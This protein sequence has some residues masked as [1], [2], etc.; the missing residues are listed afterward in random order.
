M[1]L[2]IIG[3]VLLALTST[4]FGQQ[5]NAEQQEVWDM[6]ERCWAAIA[7]D[8]ANVLLDCF[9]DDYSFWWAE[10]VLPFRK[11]LVSSMVPV[12]LA[13]EDWAGY[14]VRPAAIVVR[15]DVAIVHWGARWFLRTPEGTL[16]PV[17]ERA[18]MTLVRENGRW[19]Y[20]GGGGSPV[21]D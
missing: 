5:L 19:R 13:A 9:D 1:R 21:T 14:D 17:A 6:V 11:D 12:A 16:E 4:A 3:M 10:D 15:G 18:S 2:I 7:N 8:D 20:L